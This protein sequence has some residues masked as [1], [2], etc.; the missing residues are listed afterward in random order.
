MSAMRTTLF[1]NA[2]AAKIPLWN[3]R[4]LDELLRGPFAKRE[5]FLWRGVAC[6]QREVLR[7][8]VP[9]ALEPREGRRVHITGSSDGLERG[10]GFKSLM[11][12]RYND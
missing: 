12:H 5:R 6:C 2:Q 10:D 1:S 4:Q 7:V 3:R 8:L 11:S 9:V